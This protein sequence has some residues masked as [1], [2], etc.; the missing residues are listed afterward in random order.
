MDLAQNECLCILKAIGNVIVVISPY[1]SL[2]DFD[3]G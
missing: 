2:A 1:T 3:Y